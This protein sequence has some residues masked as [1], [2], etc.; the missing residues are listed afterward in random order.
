MDNF[1]KAIEEISDDFFAKTGLRMNVETSANNLSVAFACEAQRQES[2]MP[3]IPVISKIE[4]TDREVFNG[5]LD[6]FSSDFFFFLKEQEESF[7]Q[8]PYPSSFDGEEEVIAEMLRNAVLEEAE[9]PIL[10]EWVDTSNPGDK[11]R[12][13]KYLTEGVTGNVATFREGIPVIEPTEEYVIVL[14]RTEQLF[15]IENA[16]PI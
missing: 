15:G 1:K 11:I 16:Y 4:I 7:D 2:A 3:Q 12:L 10:Q 8:S 6:A 14:M 13:R 5:K 9:E